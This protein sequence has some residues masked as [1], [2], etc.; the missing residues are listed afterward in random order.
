MEKR[1]TEISGISSHRT[2]QANQK[3]QFLQDSYLTAS[4]CI[5]TN[6]LTIP[7]E[8]SFRLKGNTNRP[9]APPSAIG[10]ARIPSPSHQP[11]YPSP[12]PLPTNRDQPQVRIS[13]P[14]RYSW[15]NALQG[16]ANPGTTE[17][18]PNPFRSRAGSRS[19]SRGRPRRPSTSRLW[20]PTNSTP[21]AYP[22]TSPKRHQSPPEERPVIA[23]PLQHPDISNIREGAS[24]G[25]D[26]PLLTLPEQRQ[27]R[28]SASTRASLQVDRSGSSLS[29]HRISLPRTVSIDLARNR[30]SGDSPLTPTAGQR[31]DKGKGKAAEEEPVITVATTLEKLTGRVPEGRQLTP[32][33]VSGISFDFSKAAMS[34]D[35]ERGPNTLNP[36]NPSGTSPIP[37]AN[38]SNVSL[39]GGIGS[40]LSSNGTSIVGEEPGEGD[41]DA[42]GP[43]HPCFPHMNM[44]VPLSS[45]LYNT[46]RIIRIRRDWM[47]EGD[48]AP[49]FSNLYPEILDPA[50]VTEQDFR[51]LIERINNELIPAFNPW[52][53]RNIF[54]GMMGLVT[55]WVWDDLGWT[56]VKSRLNRVEMWLEE[57]NRDME[58]RAKEPGTAPK[59]VSLRRTGYMNLDIQVPDPEISYP[60]TIPESDRLDSGI[61]Q[62]HVVGT[63]PENELL[64]TIPSRSQRSDH[65][66]SVS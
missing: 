16:V 39:P 30:K 40:A 25:G 42:W 55:G 56:G 52:S 4:L 26:Y 1:F 32:T 14:T 9:N 2:P 18:L 21:R 35:L 37:H 24:A 43:Q 66:D 20:N 46:T 3:L 63:P 31:L 15:R 6:P 5:S 13:S 62:G 38:D 58:S 12:S 54:D 8:E 28:H 27:Q 59:I 57:W 61:S 65:V 51:G 36:Y 53:A 41:D 10:N 17:T 44:H 60:A 22:Q 11:P 7:H 23:I 19:T 34:T 33:P 64:A 49:T 45:P 50:G 29:S 47:L 48:L